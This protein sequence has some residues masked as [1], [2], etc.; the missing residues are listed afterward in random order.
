PG[1]GS[2]RKDFAAPTIERGFGR[3]RCPQGALRK[4]GSDRS[5][6]NGI[7]IPSRGGAGAEGDCA[8]PDRFTAETRRTRRQTRRIAKRLQREQRHQEKNSAFIRVH[9][10]PSVA[11][12]AFLCVCLCVLC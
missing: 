12:P 5:R 6:R 9:P 10:C 1:P 3:A 7:S 8:A 11:T 4:I 2:L